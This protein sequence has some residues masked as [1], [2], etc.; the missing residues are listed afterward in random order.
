MKINFII[1]LIFFGL[2]ISKNYHLIDGIDKNL[3]L[4][5]DNNSEYFYFYTEVNKAKIARFHLKTQQT[6]V[7]NKKFVIYEYDEVNHYYNEESS[8]NFNQEK[9]N[10]TYILFHLHNI[11]S[12]NTKYIEFGTELYFD[13]RTYLNISI[14]ARIDLISEEYNLYNGKPL[15]IFNLASNYSY[16]LYLEFF[17]TINISFKIKNTTQKPFSDIYIHE[18]EERHSPSI[19]ILNKQISFKENNNQLISSFSYARSQSNYTKYI[20]LQ[21]IPSF[22]ISELIAEYEYSIT[23]INLFDDIWNPIDNLKSNEIP[24]LAFNIKNSGGEYQLFNNTSLNV[25]N[26]KSNENYSFYTTPTPLNYIR[27]TLTMNYNSNMTINPFSY[28][29]IKT[30]YKGNGVSIYGVYNKSISSIRNEDELIISVSFNTSNSDITYIFFNITPLYNIDY[31]IANIDITD[32]YIGLDNYKNSKGIFYFLKSQIKY[33]I[34][35]NAWESYITKLN[36]KVYNMIKAPFSSIVIYEC[37][38]RVGNFSYCE[39][40]KPQI[41]EFKKNNDIYEATIEKKNTLNK[42]IYLF[43][44]IMPEYDI[45][46]MIAETT[47]DEYSKNINISALIIFIIE[48]IILILMIL[49]IINHF[50]KCIPSKSKKVSLTASNNQIENELIS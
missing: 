17:E 14:T 33:Y 41:I 29:L 1:S 37:F 25:T 5:K 34:E 44:E 22:N 49:Y 3:I 15:D 6:C 36:L 20:A 31:M 18:L 8:E 46:Y 42:H 24:Y 16:Y 48:I 28:V 26:L 9:I 2:I 23:S 30:L 27:L 50:R 10:N 35:M 45:Q 21:I 11:S 7:L 38:K 39:K 13:E 40:I 32:C 19:Q 47:I 4:T 12:P 43:I